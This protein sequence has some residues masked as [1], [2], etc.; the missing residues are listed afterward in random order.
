MGLTSSSTQTPPKILSRQKVQ[1][2]KEKVKDELS[3]SP[4]P[5]S[6]LLERPHCL[7]WL[8]TTLLILLSSTTMAQRRSSIIFIRHIMDIFWSLYSVY[9][10]YIIF[11]NSVAWAKSEQQSCVTGKYPARIPSIRLAYE[12]S[13]PI[14]SS[15]AAYIFCTPNRGLVVPRQ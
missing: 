12:Y 13:S 14:R 3:I 2:E 10:S 1:E 5:D 9:C 7:V 8:P 4:T 11:S 15:L 6:K